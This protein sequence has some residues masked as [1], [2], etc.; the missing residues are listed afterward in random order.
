MRRVDSSV[1][2]EECTGTVRDV[3]LP[4]Q[5]NPLGDARRVSEIV[6]TG[7]PCAGKTTALAV[8]SQKLSDYGYQV[9]VC[10]ETASLVINAGVAVGQLA[11]DPATD[12]RKVKRSAKGR[13]AV[14]EGESGLYLV[15]ELDRSSQAVLADRDQLTPLFRD[16]VL[17]R[18]TSLS[19][20]RARLAGD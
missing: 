2:G 1:A 3:S 7:G 10:P 11:Q 20:I 17:L 5:A 16:G 8:L 6:L 12:V 13:V 15:D 18:R 9:L 19:E 14:L 4:H